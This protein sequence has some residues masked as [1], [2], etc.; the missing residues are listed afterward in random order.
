MP[1]NN[2]PYFLSD[3]TGNLRF[4]SKGASELRPYFAMAGIDINNINTMDD[5]YQARK[6]ASPYFMEWMNLRAKNWPD[7][8]QFQLLK[9]ALTGQINND[10]PSR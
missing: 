6:A 4:T 3:H 1:Q 7:N 5:Y 9:N 2:Q 8:D 10:L